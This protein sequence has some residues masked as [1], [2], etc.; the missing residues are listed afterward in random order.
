M[1]PRHRFPRIV[2]AALAAATVTAS[3]GVAAA[4]S[5]GASPARAPRSSSVNLTGAGSTFDA[6]FFTLA[7]YEYHRNI[8]KN[9]T[10]NYAAIG[11][12]GGESAIEQN[13]VNFGA[14][15]VP[16]MASDLKQAKGP[17]VQVPVALGG[18]AIAYNVKGVHGGLHLTGQVLADIFLGQITNWDSSQIQKI[19]PGVKLPNASITVCHRADGSGTSYAFTNYLADVSSA[20][21]SKVGVGKTVSWPVGLGGQGNSGVAGLIKDTPDSIGYIELAYAIKNHFTYAE[22]KNPEGNFV[23]PT[24][25]SVADEAA[26]RKNMDSTHFRIVDLHGNKYAYPISTFSW[27]CI[28]KTQSSTATGTALVDLAE[29]LTH[30][31]QEKA[32]YLK[33]AGLPKSVSLL[34]QNT[35]LQV[36]GPNGKTLL[37]KAAIAKYGKF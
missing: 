9:V 33:Y 10:I 5:A 30:G 7:F 20:W 15:D 35:L 22:I 8:A 2:A 3:A 4:S 34:A 28:Y 12:G 11:S 23:L 37:T 24:I 29:W 16:M 14:T 32:S 13:T 26:L 27:M 25:S 31:G 18:V 17:I 36:V 6:P 19:N 1:K 21:K